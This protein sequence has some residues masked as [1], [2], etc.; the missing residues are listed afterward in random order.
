MHHCV[1]HHDN[2]DNLLFPPFS[3]IGDHLTQ[4]IA[5]HSSQIGSGDG[6]LDPAHHIRPERR[7]GVETGLDPQYT[8]RGHLDN[9]RGD[10]G[11][12]QIDGNPKAGSFRNR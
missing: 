1:A 5:H 4:S 7:L 8:A 9:L 6:S 11:R 3:E 12:A 10:C 2:L